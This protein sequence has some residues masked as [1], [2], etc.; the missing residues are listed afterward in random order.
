VTDFND[1]HSEKHISPKTSTE[2]GRVIQTNQFDGML[3]LQFVTISALIKMQPKTVILTPK[4]SIH[5]RFQP[6]KE[7]IFQLSQ[8]EKISPLQVARISTLIR[9][10][11][12]MVRNARP[13][14]RN[15]CAS[16][17]CNLAKR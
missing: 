2:A 1:P 6:M 9:T 11:T 3:L 14:L 16:I 12:G 4:N 5:P 13:T 10:E 17:R 7:E 8:F 15:T